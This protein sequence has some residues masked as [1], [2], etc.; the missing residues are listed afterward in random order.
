MHVHIITHV[1]V[2]LFH[3][4]HKLGPSI[5]ITWN[6]EKLLITKPLQD[7]Q[8]GWVH[9]YPEKYVVAYHNIKVALPAFVMYSWDTMTSAEDAVQLNEWNS[10]STDVQ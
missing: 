3:T 10:E 9:N 4:S 8:K 7:S 2:L 6:I 1:W 5:S